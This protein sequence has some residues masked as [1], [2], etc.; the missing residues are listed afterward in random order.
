MRGSQAFLPTIYSRPSKLNT[1]ST[2]A[3]FKAFFLIAGIHQQRASKLTHVVFDFNLAK[4]QTVGEMTNSHMGTRIFDHFSIFRVHV[5]N[6]RKYSANTGR[7]FWLRHF[8]SVQYLIA[9]ALIDALRLHRLHLFGVFKSRLNKHQ[10]V[11]RD[12]FFRSQQSVATRQSVHKV[13]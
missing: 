3:R 8:L 6:K 10:S 9:P 13:F 7:T 4:A 11:G 1:K 2:N 5:F 12:K